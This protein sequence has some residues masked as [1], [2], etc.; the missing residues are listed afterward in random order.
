MKH[1][2]SHYSQTEING[3]IVGS[4]HWPLKSIK[5]Y[6]QKKGVELRSARYI[7]YD[8]NYGFDY[9]NVNLHTGK[10]DFSYNSD[11]IGSMLGI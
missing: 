7:S 8:I 9:K 1:Y 4:H 10:S 2:R 6:C 5:S 3:K 11:P